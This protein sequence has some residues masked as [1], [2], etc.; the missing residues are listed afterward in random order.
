MGTVND[1]TGGTGTTGTGTTGAAATGKDISWK[2]NSSALI[3]GTPSEQSDDIVWQRDEMTERC[4]KCDYK[5]TIFNRR[6]HC[7]SC[8]YIFCNS[9]STHRNDANQRICDRCRPWKPD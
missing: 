2:L 1:G 4:M 7:R 8:G 5:F 6:H 3:V 9:C